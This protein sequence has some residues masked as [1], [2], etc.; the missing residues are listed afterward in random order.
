MSQRSASV[1]SRRPYLLR[2]MH[3]WISDN[4][5]TPHI[6][7]DAQLEGVD[8]PRQYVKDGKIILN[9]SHA[10]TSALKLGNEWVEFNARFGGVTRHVKVP[11][12]AVLGIY[13]RETGQG[14]IFSENDMG[15]EPPAPGKSSAAS[16]KRRRP[17]LK[18]VK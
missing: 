12:A 8:V 11:L 4:A 1:T 17:H 16:E 7:V 15:P 2:A 5:Q 18:V 14:M 3:E 10:A 6:V 13:A 9:L